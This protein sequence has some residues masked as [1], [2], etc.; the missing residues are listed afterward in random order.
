MLRLRSAFF[1]L[2]AS[3]RVWKD[4]DMT[5][6]DVLQAAG[7]ATAIATSV[8]L[9]VSLWWRRVDRKAADWIT[10]GVT[11]SWGGDPNGNVDEP[12][13]ECTLANVGDASGFRL[14]LLGYGCLPKIQATGGA[15][16][17]IPVIP[18]GDELQ[19]RA[20][21]DTSDWNHAFFIILWVESPTRRKRR[22]TRSQ[23]VW[24]HE[25]SGPPLYL[26]ERSGPMDERTGVIP[27]IRETEAPANW[28]MPERLA[29][30]QPARIGAGWLQMRR[31]ERAARRRVF[32]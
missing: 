14:Q 20:W 5:N 29:P 30:T 9:L 17:L 10:F 22:S 2:G 19:A 26:R 4:A 1:A 12:H 31:T 32:G 11:K 3:D 8:S 28:A 23:V 18:P 15:A 27:I 25:L 21:C 16:E 24:L 7:L 6:A 13:V